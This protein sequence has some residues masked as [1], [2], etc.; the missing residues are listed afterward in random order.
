MAVGPE[1]AQPEPAPI[2]TASLGTEVLGG[3]YRAGTSVRWR[4]RVG[5]HGRGDL[6][7]RDVL[8]TQGTVWFLG[9]AGKRG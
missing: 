4:Y 7:R 9:Q 6:R 1:V 5:A 8:L 3:I 2:A